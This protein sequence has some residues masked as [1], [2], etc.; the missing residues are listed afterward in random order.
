M[1]INQDLPN[2]KARF[3]LQC[4]VVMG[5][6]VKYNEMESCLD[7]FLKYADEYEQ[8]VDASE[9]KSVFDDQR[10]FDVI[11]NFPRARVFVPC[12]EECGS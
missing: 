3:T 12:I 8:P 11:G 5:Y 2:I 6:S 9:L 4:M 10:G 1:G 7:A